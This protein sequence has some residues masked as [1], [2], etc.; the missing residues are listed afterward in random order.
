MGVAVYCD[1]PGITAH[2]K[3]SVIDKRFTF[4]GSPNLT[5]SALQYNNESSVLIDSMEIV[6]K[7]ICYI[8]NL[9]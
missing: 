9:Y 7:I 1:D 4:I 5:Q 3:R 6:E 2:T 8:N